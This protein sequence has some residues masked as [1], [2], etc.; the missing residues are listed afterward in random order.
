MGG[1]C[2]AAFSIL[3]G[4]LNIVMLLRPTSNKIR[5]GARS[6]YCF[7]NNAFSWKL[8]GSLKFMSLESRSGLYFFANTFFSYTNKILHNQQFE[9]NR[10]YERRARTTKW[11]SA[12]RLLTAIT[13][14][15]FDVC[16]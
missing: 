12:F 2:K 1:R 8:V 15:I 7:Q 6:I 13:Q 5:C 16:I 11:R 10:S 4:V 9:N 14:V 3:G